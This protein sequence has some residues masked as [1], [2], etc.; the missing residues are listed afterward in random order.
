[1][2]GDERGEREE[3]GFG[4][5]FFAGVAV[6]VGVGDAIAAGVLRPPF[7]PA[8]NPADAMRQMG[9]QIGDSTI[10]M[11]MIASV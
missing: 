9:Y 2:G 6:G 10:S 7:Q 8:T 4:R 1:M 11:I 5:A 3:G